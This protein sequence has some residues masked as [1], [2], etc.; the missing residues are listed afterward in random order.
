MELLYGQNKMRSLVKPRDV[1]EMVELALGAVNYEILR[2][3]Y[4]QSGGR[5]V[6]MRRVLQ[7]ELYKAFELVTPATFSISPDIG[8]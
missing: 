3:A 2:S 7:M 4:T 1:N 6:V 8:K 5:E